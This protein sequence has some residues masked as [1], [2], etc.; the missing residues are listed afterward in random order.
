MRT[1][2]VV[3]YFIELVLVSALC[4]FTYL[5]FDKLFQE[6]TSVSHFY[7]EGSVELPSITVC[8]KW[9]SRKGANSS[10]NMWEDREL[11]LP[12]SEN[13]TFSEYM[14][15]VK[16]ARNIIKYADITDQ[17]ADKETM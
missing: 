3:R 17:L 8:A 16:L 15:N 1:L 10:G 6:D 11:T 4:W 14:A 5:S 2:N 9:L 13:W 7:I 12:E